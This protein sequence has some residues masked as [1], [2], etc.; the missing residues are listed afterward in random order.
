MGKGVQCYFI[1]IKTQTK[2]VKK[3]KLQSLPHPVPDWT[4]FFMHLS[5]YVWT[6]RNLLVHRRARNHP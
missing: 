4:I 3:W 2:Q 6:K 1:P 5:I